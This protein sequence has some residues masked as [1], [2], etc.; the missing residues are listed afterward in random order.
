MKKSKY[1]I[2]SVIPVALLLAVACGSAAAVDDNGGG[3]QNSVLGAVTSPSGTGSLGTE[4]STS[5]QA[6]SSINVSG[7]SF[8][9]G[10]SVSG[11]GT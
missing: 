5:G 2:G 6:A 11:T 8:E 7:I 9:G 1:I 4:G 10:I 3:T